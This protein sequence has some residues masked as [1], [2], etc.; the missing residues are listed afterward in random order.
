MPCHLLPLLLLLPLFVT[1]GTELRRITV[2]TSSAAPPCVWSLAVLPNGTIVSGDGDGAVQFWD[3]G[4]GTLLSRHQQFAADVL[5]LTAS[6]DGSSV[7]ASGVDPRVSFFV[8]INCLLGFVVSLVDWVLQ[9]SVG[10][11]AGCS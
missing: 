5:A 11:C 3:G 2:G 7:W 1:A 6:P 8:L 4:F 9:C 10:W